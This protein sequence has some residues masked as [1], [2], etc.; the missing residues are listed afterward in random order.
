MTTHNAN[1]TGVPGNVLMSLD[2]MVSEG[3][4]SLDLQETRHCIEYYIRM[5]MDN[6]DV[7]GA[8]ET[9]FSGMYRLFQHASDLTKGAIFIPEDALRDALRQSL[10]EAF[11]APSE[12]ARLS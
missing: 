3:I 8:P 2:K 12:K 6:L 5:Y 4:A 9:T 7:P 11:R 1:P 10:S